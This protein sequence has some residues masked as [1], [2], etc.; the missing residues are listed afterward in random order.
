MFYHHFGQFHNFSYRPY[1]VYLCPSTK[2]TEMLEQ[3][4]G[5]AVQQTCVRHLTNDRSTNHF[6][7]KT[8]MPTWTDTCQKSGKYVRLESDIAKK[9]FGK[10]L[11]LFKETVPDVVQC[12]PDLVTSYLVTNPDLVTVLQKTIFQYTKT[13]HL[14]TI[15]YFLPPRFSD[16][17]FGLF[18]SKTPLLIIF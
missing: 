7:Q 5:G 4:T 12:N 16:T 3:G 13:S 14:V 6:I 18:W 15:W 17:K 11:I 9:E 1:R 8:R 2:L 10:Q